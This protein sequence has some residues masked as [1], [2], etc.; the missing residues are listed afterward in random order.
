MKSLKYIYNIITS[1]PLVFKQTQKETQELK[2]LVAKN[3]IPQSIKILRA[4]ETSQ[5]IN[6]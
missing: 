6:I 5:Q 4:P 2:L 3:L 1:L